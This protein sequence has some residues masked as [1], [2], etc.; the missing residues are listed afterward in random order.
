MNTTTKLVSTAVIGTA[1]AV[2][3]TSPAL[4]W[5]PEGKI[6]KEV[7]NV[8]AGTAKS[9]AN[10]AAQAV[11]AKP[12]DILT[13]TITISNPAKPAG[14]QFNDLAFVKLKDML[15]EGVELVKDP[16]ARNINEDLP[17]IVPGKSITKEL[18]VK[19]TATTDTVITNKAC[20]EGNSV[21]KDAPRNG[22]DTAVVKVIV[23]KTPVTPTEEPKTPTP[24]PTPAPVVPDAAPAELPKAG[25]A[26]A[27]AI[28]GLATL[29]GYVGNLVR[30]RNKR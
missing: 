27:L 30:L 14:N 16:S 7:T 26:S 5:H 28:G 15:P 20:F 1:L 10:T 9:D 24:A 23:P 13:Y 29:T 17:T 18:T 22:C 4:A 3:I 19:V 25:A 2:S 21:V 11:A 12:G 6:V 8:T